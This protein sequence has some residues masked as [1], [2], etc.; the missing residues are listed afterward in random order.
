[1]IYDAI[2]NGARSLAFYGGNIYRCWDDRDEGLGWN[3]TFWDDVLERPRPRDQRRQPARARARQPRD[4]AGA[5]EQRPDDAG[6]QPQGR[7][8]G[9]RLGDRGAAR[10]RL[11]ARDDLRAARRA[12]R[13]GTVYTGGPHGERGERLVHRQLRALGRARLPL[14]R[15]A[16]A[17]PARAA[18]PAARSAA[19]AAAAGPTSLPTPPPAVARTALVSRG[20]SAGRARAG[21]PFSVRLRVAGAWRPVARGRP[22]HGPRRK[23]LAAAARQALEPRP[24]RRARGGCRRRA[25]GKR[26][27]RHRAGDEPRR[28]GRRA[29]SR[30]ASAAKPSSATSP[31]P[32]R[33]ERARLGARGT[34]GGRA[35][36]RARTAAARARAARARARRRPRRRCG[37]R[38]PSAAA[39]CSSRVVVVRD[40]LARPTGRVVD[41]VAVAAVGDPRGELRDALAA[42]RGSRRAG[43]GA[44]RGRGRR[45]A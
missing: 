39:A 1:M 18:G 26:L 9:R 29:R 3:W 36:R 19:A 34:R 6:D 21:R 32:S 14:P 7:D 12:S 41:R 11:A 27:P 40:Q 25:Q 31:S 43:P 17:A 28:D 13:A 16:A 10:R 42:T 37:R 44:S 45:S 20:L 22:L 33:A 35:S 8:R 4:D 23:A 30:G 38:R 24:S 5:A 15:R 2:I